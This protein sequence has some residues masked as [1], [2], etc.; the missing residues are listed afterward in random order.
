MGNNN[1]SSQQIQQT[2]TIY[3]LKLEQGKYYVGKT[4][5][6]DNRIIDHF[7]NNGSM[8]TKTYKPIEVID[9]IDNIDDY[10]EDKYTKI[11]MDK[12]GIDNVR[13]GSYVTMILPE[14]QLLSLRKESCSSSNKCFKCLK[15]GHFANQC[16]ASNVVNDNIINNVITRPNGCL[17]CGR[18]NHCSIDC[19]AKTHVN[20]NYI[21]NLSSSSDD[22]D[23]CFRCGREGHWVSDCFAKRHISGKVLN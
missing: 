8:W 19:F 22:D 6:L 16:R 2:H 12:Y 10:D 3:V 14:Y 9:T 1:N 7:T 5:T 20:G 13:G 18:K 23:V 4:T 11:Y 21:T 15:E 17:R